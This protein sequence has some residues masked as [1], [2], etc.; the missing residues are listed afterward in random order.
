MTCL[1]CIHQ[2]VCGLYQS[3]LQQVSAKI[4][5]AVPGYLDRKVVKEVMTLITTE[6]GKEL[7]AG[8]KHYKVM[9]KK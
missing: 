1:K 2:K 9:E 3:Q 6:L 7:A 5:K 8:C 4:E